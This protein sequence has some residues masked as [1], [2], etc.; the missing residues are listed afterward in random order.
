MRLA[1]LLL[2]LLSLSAP[3]VS[4]QSACDMS[5]VC[6]SGAFLPTSIAGLLF[7]YSAD[8]INGGACASQPSNGTSLLSTVWTDRSAAARNC[9]W[10]SGG[11]A[12]F[13]TNILNSKP[14][15]ALA[16]SSSC[17]FGSAITWPG[18]ETIFVVFKVTSNSVFNCFIGHGSASNFVAYCISSGA[19]QYATS[20]GNGAFI[21]GS[22]TVTQGAFHQA[23][24]SY[25]NS[26]GAAVVRLASAADN[27]A[28][29]AQTVSTTQTLLFNDNDAA[30]FT[31]TI[32]EI[33]AYNTVL[34]LANKQSVETYLNTKYGI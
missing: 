24:M 1:T 31:G 11:T 4:P 29:A 8:C 28:T 22:V 34:S 19:I 16:S 10:G 21:Q 20:Q 3:S 17:T 33:F 30:F 32:V 12:T 18:T 25:N 15:I 7:W 2:S 6:P 26:T 13:N 14:A 9:T 23:N 27:S 5:N